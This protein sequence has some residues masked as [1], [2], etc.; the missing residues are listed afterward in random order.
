M[1][2]SRFFPRRK[3]RLALALLTAL[4]AACSTP[5]NLSQT[6]PSPL[7]GPDGGE[8]T[9]SLQLRMAD[10]V[11]MR[12]SAVVR[13]T[14]NWQQAAI[15]Q[16]SALPGELLDDWRRA[17]L[18][19]GSLSLVVMEV[20]QSPWIAINPLTPRNPASLMKL[21]TT[22]AALEGLGANHRW[23][24]ELHTDPQTVITRDGHLA[25]PLYLKAGGDPELQIEDV[26]RLFRELRLKGV[27]SLEDI[28][29]DRSIFGDVAIDPGAFDN[30]PDRVYNASPDAL[31]IGY[32]A[33][34]LSYWPDPGTGEWQ[35][36]LDPELPNLRVNNQIQSRRGACQGTR[37]VQL[38]P[39]RAADGTPSLTLKGTLP[40]SCDPFQHYRLLLPPQEHAEQVIRRI[41]Q[42]LGGELR[43]NIVNGR[44]PATT[45]LQ[46]RHES[47]ALADIIR[48]I[49]KSSNNV[50]ARL[51][52]LALAAE[53]SPAPATPDTARAALQSVLQEQGLDFSELFVE[54]GSGLSRHA[55]VAAGSLADLLEAAWF[56]PRMP[57][58]VSSL[59][60]AGADGTVRR[61][62]RGDAAAGR[63]HLKTGTLR[64]VNALAGYVQADSGRRFILVSLVNDAQAYNARQ[65]INTL[66]LWLS[67]Q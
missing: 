20:G 8:P 57:E 29:I 51:T 62:W 34:R 30:A 23:Y 26:W 64:D 55:R 21:V 5:N 35:V 59:A 43:G 60:I 13:P 18:D 12:G 65:F 61:R 24:T 52:L 3:P 16:V 47:P 41:W 66:V 33:T 2:F 56:S 58:F 46:A 54:N 32:N 45:Q 22:F 27:R 36:A 14:R 15:T 19:D 40:S 53:A 48:S 42:Q 49:N 37:A 50:M 25:G 28:V 67:R 11:V 44:M 1:V 6:D 9:S 63:A 7:Y 39:G 4:L 10:D 38:Q 17:R 31:T